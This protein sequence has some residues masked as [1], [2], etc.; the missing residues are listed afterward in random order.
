MAIWTS[1]RFLKHGDSN[2]IYTG[3]KI[4][5]GRMVKQ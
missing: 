2:V 3:R 5:T 4:Y 1:N